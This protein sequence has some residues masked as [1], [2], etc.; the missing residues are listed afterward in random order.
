LVVPL[1]QSKVL[2]ATSMKLFLALFALVSLG[3]YA[4]SMHADD[5]T[6][7]L[8]ALGGTTVNVPSVANANGDVF[9]Y[10][11]ASVPAFHDGTLIGLYNL[12][13]TATYVDA[14]SSLPAG[15]ASALIV[16]ESCVDV[17]VSFRPEH[18]PCTGLSFAYTNA[19][20]GNILGVTGAV[21]IGADV[22]ADTIVADAGLGIGAG[23]ETIGFGAPP[24][25]TPEPGTLSLMG[26]GLLGIAGVVRRKFRG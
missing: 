14:G 25:A 11:A 16:T 17:T 3:V 10:D 2:E 26:T 13:F 23:T 5:L 24:S 18:N 15:D 21:N 12:N 22:N 7:N 20:A 8:T 1:L 19:D 9:T 6:L 4:P